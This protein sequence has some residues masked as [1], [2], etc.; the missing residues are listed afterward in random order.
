MANKKSKDCATS[1]S[2]FSQIKQFH[3]MLDIPYFLR[4]PLVYTL[5]ITT[6]TLNFVLVYTSSHFE[7][8][9]SQSSLSS[10]EE[11]RTFNLWRCL[12]SLFNNLVEQTIMFV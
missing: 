12:T 1:L 7:Y 8:S 4:H 3:N 5:H 9:P 11:F 10:D 2:S 6:C